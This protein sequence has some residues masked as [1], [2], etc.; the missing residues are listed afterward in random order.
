ML[1]LSFVYT[2]YHLSLHVPSYCLKYLSHCLISLLIKEEASFY[3]DQIFMFKI[4][5]FS[6]GTSAAYPFYYS[7]WP[8]FVQSDIL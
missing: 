2:Q 6:H 5:M 3:I 8:T 1:V 7:L 4:A